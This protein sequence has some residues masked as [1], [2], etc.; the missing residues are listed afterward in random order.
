MAGIYFHIPFCKQACDYCNFHFSTQMKN[1]RELLLSMLKEL[2]LRKDELRH[3]KI[4]SIYFGGGTP[5]LL[6]PKEIAE[7]IEAVNQFFIV[8]PNPEISLE[9]NP[10]DYVSG[11][12]SQLK[13]VGVNRLSIGVQSFFEEELNMMNRAHSVSQC[14]EVLK[15]ATSH[16]ENFSLD[17]IYGM[18]Q[19]SLHSW[20]ENLARALS[21][22]PPHISSYALTV[23]PKT[24]LAHKVDK[25]DITLLEEEKV[26]EQF[27][28]MVDVL[29]KAGYEHYELSNFGKPNFHSVNNSSYWKGEPYL[30]IG[31]SA[32]SFDGDQRSWNVSNNPKYI[33]SINADTLPITRENL[34]L[35]DHYNEYIM[36]RLRTQAG[37][38]LAEINSKFGVRYGALLE[39]MAQEGVQNRFLFWDGDFLR[40]SR[41]GKFLVD[42]L[43]SDLFLINL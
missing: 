36:T 32:H 10:D 30:G 41:Q 20:T 31:P 38:S 23:E 37:V 24:L 7:F 40:V 22:A 8:V 9:M 25:K 43:A 17:L 27:D 5:S 11:Y 29:E 19:S 2:D 4:E 42:G 18:P 16:F 1:K 39:E 33:K 3:H 26:A 6:S 35:I 13:T 34:S 28:R 12:F 15:A 14:H 21:Y